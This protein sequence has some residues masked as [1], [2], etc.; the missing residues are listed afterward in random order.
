VPAL[1]VLL[2]SLLALAAPLLSGATGPE[3]W[4]ALGP[5]NLYIAPVVLPAFLVACAKT[6]RDPGERFALAAM[7]VAA[8]L[9]AIQPDASQVLA[10][11]LAFAVLLASAEKRS[12]AAFAAL[13]LTVLATGLAFA[14]PDP[15]EPIPYVEGVF[16]LAFA[17]SIIAGSLVAAGALAFLAG[18]VFASKPRRWIAAVAAY[19]SVLFGCSI[20]GLTPAPLI[21]YGAGPWLGFGLLLITAKWHEND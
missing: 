4:I 12:A 10:L 9:L 6:L 20:V 18:L 16:V 15:L 7:V 1:A 8:A 3:R 14:R 21:G 11:L 19:Y 5:L 2:L 17:H 13:G